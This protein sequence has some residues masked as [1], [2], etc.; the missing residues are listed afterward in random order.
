MGSNEGR[1]VY[2]RMNSGLH[3][4]GCSGHP[5]MTIPCTLHMSE[6]GEF[7]L[8]ISSACSAQTVDG[9]VD[10]PVACGHARQ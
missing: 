10:Y 7:C 8:F 3:Q 1:G 9:P 6:Q 2:T 5:K 4:T